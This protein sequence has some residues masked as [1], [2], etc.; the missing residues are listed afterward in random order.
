MIR[1]NLFK[2]FLNIP[3]VFFIFSQGNGSQWF[4]TFLKVSQGPLKFLWVTQSF[5][6]FLGS[7]RFIRVLQGF[8][9]SQ[10]PQ[11]FFNFLQIVLKLLRE[12]FKSSLRF[13]SDGFH[14]GFLK[15]FK[16]HKGSSGFHSVPQD[17]WFQPYC[18]FS[19]FW[20]LGQK[21]LESC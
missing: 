21:G 16:I 4:L 6:L 8:L 1:M 12:T 9:R 10:D 17:V 14:Y 2:G 13:F 19:L 3:Q 5:L 7:F 15:F 11:R 20:Q 18:T